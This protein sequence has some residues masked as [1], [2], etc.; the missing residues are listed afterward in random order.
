MTAT[1]LKTIQTPLDSFVQAVPVDRRPTPGF[2]I[3]VGLDKVLAVVKPTVSGKRGWMHRFQHE[4]FL[5]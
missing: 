2:Q 1:I 4:M 5:Y 3:V